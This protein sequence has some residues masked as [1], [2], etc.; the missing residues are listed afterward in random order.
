MTRAV[1]TAGLV[2]SLARGA[3]AQ[4]PAAPAPTPP[5]ATPAEQVYP[6]VRVGMLSYLQYAAELKNRAGYNAFDIT[7]AYVN[8]NAQLSRNVR[9]RFTS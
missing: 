5:P 6:N 1:V 4:P 2:L 3:F 8:V 9:F 7:R